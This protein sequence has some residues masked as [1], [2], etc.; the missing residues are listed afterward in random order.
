MDHFSRAFFPKNDW[1][2]WIKVRGSYGQTGN[3]NIGG[4]RFL[5]LPSSWEMQQSYVWPFS[6]YNFGSTDGSIL[7]PWITGKSEKVVGNP[8]VTWERKISYNIAA[9]IRLFRDRLSFTADFLMKTE[10]IFL[11]LLRLYRG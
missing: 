10:I 11:Q 1:V 6:G 7:N 4:K 8:D 5:Y 9:E 2:T 3:S